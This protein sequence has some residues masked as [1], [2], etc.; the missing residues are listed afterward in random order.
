MS[1][2]YFRPNIIAPNHVSFDKIKDGSSN[3]IVIAVRR[4]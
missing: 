3:T 2:N 1:F 4:S